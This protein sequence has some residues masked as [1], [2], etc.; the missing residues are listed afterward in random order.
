MLKIRIEKIKGLSFEGYIN[1]EDLSPEQAAELHLTDDVST[2]EVV[3]DFDIY[4][5]TDD[6][7]IDNISAAAFN[8]IFDLELTEDNCDFDDLVD[9]LHDKADLYSEMME[10][11]MAAAE[12]RCEDR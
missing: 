10:R 11:A 12:S 9:Q 7:Q 4:G 5:D 1:V 2:V 3:G 6:V 8:D